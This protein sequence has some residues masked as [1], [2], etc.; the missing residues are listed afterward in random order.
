MKASKL[1]L[2]V[3]AATGMLMA[4]SFVAFAQ[5]ANSDT[6]G[7]CTAGSGADMTKCQNEQSNQQKDG[8]VGNGANTGSAT[9]PGGIGTGQNTGATNTN[10]N[11][12]NTNHTSGGQN[13]GGADAGGANAGGG[14]QSGNS[15]N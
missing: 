1:T 4:S 13:A 10:A 6:T 11:P 8:S 14:S 3:G 15:G 2:V 9:D 7:G 5:T 12:G